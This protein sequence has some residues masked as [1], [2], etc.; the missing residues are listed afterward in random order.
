MAKHIWLPSLLANPPERTLIYFICGNP[1]LIAFYSDFLNHLRYLLDGSGQKS[2][3]KIAYDI[4][5]RN[6][7]GFADQDFDIS[8]AQS[9]PWNI[10]DQVDIIYADLVRRYLQQESSQRSSGC[11]ESLQE[12]VKPF[13]SVILVGHSLG[14]LIAMKILVRHKGNPDL[15]MRCTIKR[16]AFLF[17]VFEQAA[18]SSRGRLIQRLRR[19][20][21]F[22]SYVHI[23]VQLVLFLVPAALLRAILVHIFSFSLE[24]ADILTKLLKSRFGGWQLSCLCQSALDTV[25]AN[26]WDHGLCNNSCNPNSSDQVTAAEAQFLFLYA[27]H[28]EWITNEVRDNFIIGCREQIDRGNIK[29]VVNGGQLTHSFCV[30]QSEHLADMANSCSSLT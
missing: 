21:T 25:Q 12:P 2:S 28:D 13:K 11:S 6:L 8:N 29:V 14:A 3:K 1:G 9:K 26:N 17:P 15:S 30:D 4:F 10:E 7:A 16:A 5:G 24:P 23:Y 27:K 18:A 19:L 20:P 22:D